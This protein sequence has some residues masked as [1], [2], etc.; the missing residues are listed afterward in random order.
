MGRS[1]PRHGRVLACALVIPA[2]LAAMPPSGTAVPASPGPVDEP[3]LTV[4]VPEDSIVADGSF[5]GGT[6]SFTSGGNRRAAVVPLETAPHG[7]QVLEV[8]PRRR[9]EFGIDNWPGSVTYAVARAP[10]RAT[11]YVAATGTQVGRS[12]TLT[13]RQTA[14]DGTTLL[15]DVSEPVRLTPGFQR[16][17]ATI[18]PRDPGGHI[19]IV[20]S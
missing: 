18:V 14:A 9:G 7:T 4:S 8:T 1:M 3:T 17:Q 2:L 10:Y 6:N 19:D 12:L 11:A 16:V 13:V 15:V 5:E 20:T